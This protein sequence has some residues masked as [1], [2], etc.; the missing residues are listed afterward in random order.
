LGGSRPKKEYRGRGR[1]KRKE[2]KINPKIC[3][4]KENLA[5]PSITEEKP[6][7]EK[8]KKKGKRG[9]RGARKLGV[10]TNTVKQD[11]IKQETSL[12]LTHD[13]RRGCQVNRSRERP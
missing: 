10:E 13:V 2:T 7:Q 6:L 3:K 4:K 1:R 9:K 12:C 5:N 11:T 8:K